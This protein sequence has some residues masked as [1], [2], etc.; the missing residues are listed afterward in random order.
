M[1]C[2]QVQ[3]RLNAY[4]DGELPAGMRRT[5]E[6]HLEGCSACARELEEHQGLRCLL[7][8]SPRVSAP[9][10][11]AR[12]VRQKASRL[13]VGARS[14]ALPALWRLSPVPMRAAAML[15][16]GFGLLLGGLMGS[17]AAAVRTTE[18]TVS[19]GQAES[20]ISLDLIGA[21][22][23]G[24]LAEDYLEL[25]GNSEETENSG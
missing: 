13:A 20:D 9:E 5:L 14:G 1:N 18:Q 4:L 10:G 11:F 17:S 22:A 21:L 8:A 15:A 6:A 3:R 12:S 24:S 25:T 19:S 23:P 16:L 7:D 2:R